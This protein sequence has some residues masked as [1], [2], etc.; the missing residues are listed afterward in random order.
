MEQEI[1]SSQTPSPINPQLPH[2]NL[3]P[4]IWVAVLI[5]TALAVGYLVW[6][7]ASKKWPFEENL[8]PSNVSTNQTGNKTQPQVMDE[9]TKDWKTYSDQ[10]RKLEFK[11]PSYLGDPIYKV[12]LTLTT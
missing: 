5:V 8:Q 1:N 3:H 12:L 4:G 6:A 2:K 7:N 10:E 9:K 11:Y